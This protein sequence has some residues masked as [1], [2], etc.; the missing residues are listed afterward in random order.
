MRC[1]TELTF[2]VATRTDATVSAASA[3]A[4]AGPRA[5][6][7]AGPQPAP[8]RA[9]HADVRAV[10]QTEPAGGH[11]EPVLGHRGGS[12]VDPDRAFVALDHPASLLDCEHDLR[13]DRRPNFVRAP[14]WAMRCSE[15]PS[16]TSAGAPN[17]DNVPRRAG[18]PAA[19][20][21]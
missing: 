5:A 1:L 12:H 4:C 9:L 21:P 11:P 19:S 17:A 20:L 15:S 6:A 8:G 3:P 7:A 10:A 18:S 14:A 13:T 2:Q 16:L